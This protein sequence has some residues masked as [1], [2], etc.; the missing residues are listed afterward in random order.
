M[1]MRRVL[2]EYARREY[3]DHPVKVSLREAIGLTLNDDPSVLKVNEIMNDLARIDPRR[4]RMPFD[5]IGKG[6]L[7]SRRA[8][9]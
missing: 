2:V 8:G 7:Q 1:Q 9:I 4:A 3:R 5:R 6:A